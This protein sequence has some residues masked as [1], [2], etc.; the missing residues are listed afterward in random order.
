MNVK[1]E[2]ERLLKE[3]RKLKEPWRFVVH[4]KKEKAEIPGRSTR[5]SRLLRLLDPAPTPPVVSIT[6]SSRLAY[7]KYIVQAPCLAEALEFKRANL[8]QCWNK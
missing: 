7:S 8:S 5:A 6:G 3:Y 1:D 2:I 4:Q